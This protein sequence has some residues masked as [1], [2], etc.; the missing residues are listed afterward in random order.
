MKT[1]RVWV[2]FEK[3]AVGESFTAFGQLGTKS[4]GVK[5]EVTGKW[6]RDARTD[7]VLEC[8][9]NCRLNDGHG[10]YSGWCGPEDRVIVARAC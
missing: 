5:T 9:S 8:P 2:R 4:S 1:K 7:S 3:V 10:F 6:R